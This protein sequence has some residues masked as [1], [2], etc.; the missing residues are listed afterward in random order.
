M[1]EGE[2]KEEEEKRREEKSEMKDGVVSFWPRFGRQVNEEE[3]NV[4][5]K[6]KQCL[7]LQ[8]KV[9]SLTESLC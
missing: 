4:I 7:E 8:P 6:I 5:N 9:F 2:R 1:K 3:K